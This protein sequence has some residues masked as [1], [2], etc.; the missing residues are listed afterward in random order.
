MHSW[1]ANEKISGYTGSFPIKAIFLLLKTELTVTKVFSF[2]SYRA[3]RSSVV[4]LQTS[5]VNK[6]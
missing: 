5:R 2:Y 6:V 1:K 4:S 3:W